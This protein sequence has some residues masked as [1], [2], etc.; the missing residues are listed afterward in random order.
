[1]TTN[2]PLLALQWKGYPRVHAARG[3]LL[4]H[5]LTVPI[6]IGGTLAVVI[7]AASAIGGM[8][9]TTSLATAAGGLVAMALAVAAQGAGH[10]REAERPEPFRGPGDVIARLLLEQWI[11]F[12]RFVLT[13]GFARALRASRRP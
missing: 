4:I 1:M 9:W 13:G 5:I 8:P 10:A 11:T 12:P 2:Q 7:G 6:F 3:N